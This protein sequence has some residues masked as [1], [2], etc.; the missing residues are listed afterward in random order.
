MRAL[1]VSSDEVRWEE[2][3]A[4]CVVYDQRTALA[5]CVARVVDGHTPTQY[6]RREGARG[7]GVSAALRSPYA[8]AVTSVG[9]VERVTLDDSERVGREGLPYGVSG[10][11]R[12]TLDDSERA[13]SVGE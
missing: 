12:V 10:G 3:R 11:E 13:G 2:V 9:R 7:V 1:H 6:G 5:A 4:S 8:A